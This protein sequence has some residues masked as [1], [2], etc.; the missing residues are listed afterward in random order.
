M[1][2][3]SK[4]GI[5]NFNMNLFLDNLSLDGFLKIFEIDILDLGVVK[6][7]GVFNGIDID[8]NLDLMVSLSEIYFKGDGIIE[9]FG[10][11][12]VKVDF[13]FFLCGIEVSELSFGFLKFL[14]V[15]IKELDG[16]IVLG[17]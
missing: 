13:N 14:D 11:E 3:G 17:G 15:Y 1:R 5:F 2:V 10:I 8:L 16:G 7:F 9:L 4:E 6:I 12:V